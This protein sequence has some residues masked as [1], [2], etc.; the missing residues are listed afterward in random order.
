MST[1]AM[2]GQHAA[3]KARKGCPAIGIPWVRWGAAPRSRVE[4]YA[5]SV[6]QCCMSRH[7]PAFKS[8][9]VF[10]WASEPA[11]ERPTDFGRST[12]FSVMS[13]YSALQP[14]PMSVRRRR[15][16]R[17]G[18]AKLAIAAVMTL[19]MGVGALIMMGHLLRA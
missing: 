10:D 13:D 9:Q 14:A 2:S 1:H 15:Q 12:G 16:H 8:T 18:M 17:A 4:Q 7:Q 3:S 19:G 6:T 11:D 5:T